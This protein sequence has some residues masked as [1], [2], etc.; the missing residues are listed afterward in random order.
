[1]IESLSK[2]I[3]IGSTPASTR[4]SVSLFHMSMVR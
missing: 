3:P 4:V 2:L 1:M